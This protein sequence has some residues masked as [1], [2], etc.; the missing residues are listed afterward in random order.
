[1]D[2]NSLFRSNTSIRFQR[3]FQHLT[4]QDKLYFMLQPKAY[5]QQ[6]YNWV[7]CISLLG[8]GHS[9]VFNFGRKIPWQVS[10]PIMGVSNFRFLLFQYLIAWVGFSRLVAF[11]IPVN[12][13]E[14]REENQVLSCMNSKIQLPSNTYIDPELKTLLRI[15]LSA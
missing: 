12:N 11:S 10:T 14:E 2:Y 4:E 5:C 7:G 8:I 13:T 6:Q 1:M 9:I 15:G 3:F